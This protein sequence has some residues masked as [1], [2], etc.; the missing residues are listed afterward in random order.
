MAVSLCTVDGSGYPTSSCTALTAPS[1]FVAGTLVFTDPASTALAANTTYSLLLVTPGGDFL[2]LSVTSSNAEDTGGAAGWTIADA[3]DSKPGTVWGT[4]TT[5]TSFLITI[6]GT[7]GTTPTNAAPTAA[8]NTVTTGEDMA[9]AFTAAD[10]GF[11]DADAGDTLASVRIV[12][13]P[14]LGTLALD[15][16]AVM[17]DD[18]ATKAQLD[19]G[20]LTFTPVVGESGDPYT[21]FTFKVNDGTDDSV[22]AYTMTI[23]VMIVSAPDAPTGL[24]AT[25]SGQRAVHGSTSPGPPRST[26]AAPPSTSWARRTPPTATTPPPPGPMNNWSAIS[27]TPAMPITFILCPWVTS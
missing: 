11:M 10:F 19:D 22:S 27:I 4:T 16:T 12:T 7:L 9:Y 17:A 3:H 25:A 20:D 18:V 24:A 6:K 21:T 13:P 14:A 5:G 2:N 23:D 1:S 26:P 15:G 8:D